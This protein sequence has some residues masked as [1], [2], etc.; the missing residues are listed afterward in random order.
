[1]S[2]T[3]IGNKPKNVLL[4]DASLCIGCSSCQA[5]CQLEHDLPACSRTVRVLRLGPFEEDEGLTMSFLP[6]TCF[7]CE[8]PACVAE[9][10]TG[11]MQKRNDG[12]VFSDPEIC[13]GC[14]TCAV[15]CP[16]GIP[17]LNPD[18][19]KIAKCD[20]CKDRIDRGLWPVCALKCPTE[21]LTFGGAPTVVQDKRKKEALKVARAF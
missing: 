3:Y 19:G 9:C 6:T 8:R 10:P 18:T 21:A 12:I 5:A 16:Y 1:M 2:D 15:A 4:I 14:Q 11:A 17:E 7:H 13:I 20:G